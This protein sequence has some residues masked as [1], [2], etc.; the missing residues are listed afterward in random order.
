MNNPSTGAQGVPNSLCWIKDAEGQMTEYRFNRCGHRAGMDCGPKPPGTY[1]IVLAGSSFGFGYGV[2]REKTFAALLPTELSRLTGRKVELYNES[3]AGRYPLQVTQ[4]FS[5]VLAAKPDMVLWEFAPSDIY[6][7]SLQPYH[8][9]TPQKVNKAAAFQVIDAFI[10]KSVLSL[11]SAIRS[12]LKVSPLFRNVM[13]RFLQV[14]QHASIWRDDITF[15]LR[16]FLYE[17]QDQY[18]TSFLMNDDITA[19]Y[20]RAELSPGWQTNLGHFDTDAADIEAQAK[21]A[22]I[23]FVAVLIPYRADAAMISMGEWP[24]GFDPYKLDN[25]LHSIIVSHGGIYID[26]LPDFRNLPNPE[27]Y[28]FPVDGHPNA[29]GHA[30]ISRFL[31]KEL[32]S[33]A[34]PALRVA[35]QSSVAQESGR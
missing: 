23:P 20:L 31:A 34:V 28:Y 19:G 32:T 25:E 5:E 18:V 35:A 14:W 11:R 8:A 7:S 15:M 16:H 26:I 33:G 17:S 3:F 2:A 1:R 6:N 9:I 10:M 27:Q 30:I 12:G 22:G 29:D 24:A 4:R 21:A 13:N